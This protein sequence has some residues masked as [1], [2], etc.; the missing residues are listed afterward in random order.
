M[1]SIG[2]TQGLSQCEEPNSTELGDKEAP[3]NVSRITGEE[4]RRH[5][6]SFSEMSAPYGARHPYYWQPSEQDLQ[7]W[8]SLLLNGDQSGDVETFIIRRGAEVLGYGYT[9]PLLGLGGMY[10]SLG[11]MLA[12]QPEKAMNQALLFQENLAEGVSLS[13]VSDE[14]ESYMWSRAQPKNYERISAFTCTP[15]SFMETPEGHVSESAV[16]ES[17]GFSTYGQPFEMSWSA[18]F[19]G[20]GVEHKGFSCL[21]WTKG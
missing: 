14:I 12:E 9:M 15:P 21:I 3:V 11:Q 1:A 10:E 13:D 20:K 18:Q 17:M 4:L 19:P 16:M 5:I 7:G 8:A 2:A 6:S